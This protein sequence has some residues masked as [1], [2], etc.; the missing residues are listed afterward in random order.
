[1]T[2][3]QTCALP[4]FAAPAAASR[5]LSLAG[6][7]RAAAEGGI[8]GAASQAQRQQLGLEEGGA[9]EIAK[10]GLLGAAIPA[11]LIVGGRAAAPVAAAA[12]AG[13]KRAILPML[14]TGLERVEETHILRTMG[15]D[16]GTIERLNR[17]F[18]VPELEKRGTAA[19]ADFAK[20]EL[21]D[22]A[23]IKANARNAD[24]AFLQ[25]IPDDAAF[26]KLSPEQK[27]AF[28]QGVVNKYGTQYDDVFAG[29]EKNLVDMR[30]MQ[31]IVDKVESMKGPLTQGAAIESVK[32]ELD[33]LKAAI[34][35][36]RP[37][38]IG[39]AHV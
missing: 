14:K 30:E 36:G 26:R 2:G 6:V 38:K 11:G 35:D 1:M 15:I 32:P 18:S 31:R 27:V 13:A 17:K 9:A 8:Y 37:L 4:I 34:A 33:M 19:F 39:R 3:V 21:D 22:I 10:A 16:K 7:G 28:A 23:A 24:N 5:G 12:G 25:S 29:I 20:N